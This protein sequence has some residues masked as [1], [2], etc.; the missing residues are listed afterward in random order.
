MTIAWL[1]RILWAIF[2][3][4]N[5]FSTMNL[6]WISFL[7]GFVVN[8]SFCEILNILLM[9]IIPFKCF[10]MDWISEDNWSHES[11]TNLLRQINHWQ[12]HLNGSSWKKNSWKCS[13]NFGISGI[14]QSKVKWTHKSRHEICQGALFFVVIRKPFWILLTRLYIAVPKCFVFSSATHSTSAYV[15]YITKW[16]HTFKFSPI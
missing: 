5:T 14:G 3:T 2:Y 15:L 10:V 7:F 12:P 9:A 6:I 11:T 8:K 13:I 4:R 16:W 1:N